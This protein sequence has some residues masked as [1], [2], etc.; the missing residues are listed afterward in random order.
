MG[1][2][3]TFGGFAVL[4]SLIAGAHVVQAEIENSS[5]FENCKVYED[6]TESE[7]FDGT[8]KERTY[9]LTC[10][11]DDKSSQ[12]RLWVFD[13]QPRHMYF[14]LRIANFSHDNHPSKTMMRVRCKVDEK[15]IYR[16]TFHYQSSSATAYW[17]E[18]MKSGIEK[19]D[20]LSGGKTLAFEF[21]QKEKNIFKKVQLKGVDEAT[22]EFK[23]RLESLEKN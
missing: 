10:T 22:K 12:V 15:H 23:R 21:E 4:L 16:Q 18:S 7:S 20:A 19:L 5:S 9:Y 17:Q 1:K 8:I 14:G 11:S 2:P 13:T 3:K 6:A